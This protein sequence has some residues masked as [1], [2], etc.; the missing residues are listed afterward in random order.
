MPTSPFPGQRP[1]FKVSSRRQASRTI[2]L[3]WS[4]CSK[5]SEAHRVHFCLSLPSSRSEPVA[6]L[7]K[8][9]ARYRACNPIATRSPRRSKLMG[10]PRFL[11]RSIP[12]APAAAADV[13]DPGLT[14]TAPRKFSLT[15]LL[16][17]FPGALGEP[18]GSLLQRGTT[19]P[20][21][22]WSASRPRGRVPRQVHQVDH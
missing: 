3:P 10:P 12:F 7:A 9:L 8:V 6:D 18:H 13:V 15:D 16:N 19:G 11:D 21:V 4:R 2:Q 5:R 20:R 1:P 22:D 17:V 14:S